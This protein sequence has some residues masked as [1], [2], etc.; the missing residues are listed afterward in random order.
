LPFGGGLYY[1]YSD[2][3]STLIL[4]GDA[5]FFLL[6]TWY[7]DHVIASNRGRNEPFYFPFNRIYDKFFRERKPVLVN[8]L[9]NYESNGFSLQ[10]E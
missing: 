4:F 2:L 1:R 9:I 5:I 8:D 7:F 6:L 10:E 3:F